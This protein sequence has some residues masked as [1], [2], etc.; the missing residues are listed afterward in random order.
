M[1]DLVPLASPSVATQS[2]LPSVVPWAMFQTRRCS[3]DSRGIDPVKLSENLAF[4]GNNDMTALASPLLNAVKYAF[5][6]DRASSTETA[7]GVEPSVVSDP[8]PAPGS[9]LQA[10]AMSATTA[11]ALM[12]CFLMV[13]SFP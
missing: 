3:Q 9:G 2:G 12:R 1:T 10:A 5:A 8:D 4:D 11:S 7:E 13:P 6:V